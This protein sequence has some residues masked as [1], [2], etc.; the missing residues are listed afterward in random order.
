MSKYDKSMEYVSKTQTLI[1][2]KRKTLIDK[3]TGETI[4]VNQITKRVYGQKQFWKVYLLDFLQILGVLEN[5]Q[6]D[7]L[8]YILE[9]TD[10]AN[11]TFIGTYKKIAENAKVSEPTI[12]KIMK[13]LQENNFITKIQNGVW[14]VSPLIMMKGNDYK[15]QILLNYYNDQ[16]ETNKE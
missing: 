9:N 6:L 8:I 4:E 16:Q 3:D 13:K 15:Q 14:Q 7:V 10:Q 12:A 5:K 2:E 11:N 1:G